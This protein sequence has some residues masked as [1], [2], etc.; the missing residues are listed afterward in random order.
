MTTLAR[1]SLD[2][3]EH[4]VAVGIFSGQFE[5]NVE[6][7]RGEIA[8]MIPIGPPHGD[9]QT[10][11][12]DWSIDVVPRSSIAIREQLPIRIPVS[13]SE[14]QPD[15]VWAVRRRYSQRHPD[16]HEVLLLVEVAESSLS[17]DR[18]VKLGIY[19]EAGIAD[20][21]IVNLIDQ[22]IEVYRNPA[23]REY[24]DMTIVRGDSSVSPLAIP[25]AT[26][27]SSWLFGED[28]P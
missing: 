17:I 25:E 15:L 2:H 11:L 21:W 14:P 20:Y 3:Y 13:D 6:L 5:K 24:L 4:M 7:L 26:L 9:I 18:G 23:G 19:A 28:L 27:Q 22:Q 1:F 8:T 12:L 16:P 10:L